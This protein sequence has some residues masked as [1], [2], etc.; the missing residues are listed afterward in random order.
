MSE[1]LYLNVPVNVVEDFPDSGLALCEWPDGRLWVHWAEQLKAPC[2][3]CKGEGTWRETASVG[4]QTVGMEPQPGKV[5]VCPR[6]GGTGEE[7]SP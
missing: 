6:C 2:L 7:P 3:N 1:R 4:P 5:H